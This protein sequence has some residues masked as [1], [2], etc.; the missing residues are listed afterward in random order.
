MFKLTCIT[1]DD[2]VCALYINGQYLGADDCSDERFSLADILVRLSRLPGV[3]VETATR[4]VPQ[5]ADWRWDDIADSVFATP[6]SHRKM[7]VSAFKQRLAGYPEDALCC[8]TFWLA[9]D[10]LALDASL[11][12][13][14]IDA[15]MERAED[16]H[17]A[18]IGFNW[19]YLQSVIEAVKE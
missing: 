7:T 15:A 12:D 19:E 6:V 11:D 2:G 14:T 13:N 4:P 10:F 9:D 17:D 18:N 5:N 3:F 8:G 1:L 16:C